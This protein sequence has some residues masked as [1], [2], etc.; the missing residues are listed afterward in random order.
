MRR[1]TL[2]YHEVSHQWFGNLVTMDWFDDLWL[3]EGFATFIGYSIFNDLEPDKKAWLRFHQRV[4]PSAYR[5]DAT[6]GTTPVFQ[7][8]G[9]L[10]DAKSNYG[11]IVY[12]KAPAVLKSLEA[13]LGATKF[14]APQRRLAESVRPAWV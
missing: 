5:V 13:R 8:L 9:N 4:K 6:E 3:K 10:N 12:N 2:I 1:S 14:R 11:A 7:E